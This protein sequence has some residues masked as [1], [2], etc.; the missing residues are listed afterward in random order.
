MSWLLVHRA[1]PILFQSLV[2]QLVPN[3]CYSVGYEAAIWHYKQVIA[4]RQGRGDKRKGEETNQDKRR[5]YCTKWWT[6][7]LLAHL[8]SRLEWQTSRYLQ[9]SSCIYRANNFSSGSSEFN[10]V[11]KLSC[12]HIPQT[13]ALCSA[14]S[15]TQ[16]LRSPSTPL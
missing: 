16:R 15:T 1:P 12:H 13:T 4:S 10:I 7:L 3:V 5:Q 8:V 11:G 2:L 9:V 14:P 6:R